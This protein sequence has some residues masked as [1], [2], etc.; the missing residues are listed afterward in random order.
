MQPRTTIASEA[1]L[2]SNPAAQQV[3][4]EIWPAAVITVGIGLTA[5]CVILLGY[6][7][8]RLVELAI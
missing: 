8:V 6:G 2:L 7:L 3:R 5:A 1:T 4:R